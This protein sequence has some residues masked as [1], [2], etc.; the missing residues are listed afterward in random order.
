MAGPSAGD[1]S[2]SRGAPRGRYGVV[3]TTRAVVLPATPLLV[4]GAAGRARVLDAARR[5]ALDGLAGLPADRPVVV[6][7]AGTREEGVESAPA[8]ASLAAA[9]VADAWLDP[10]WTQPAGLDPEGTGREVVGPAGVGA[11]VALLALGATGRRAG[12]E[13]VEL[14]D[15]VDP[16]DA[17][18]LGVALRGRG[19]GLVVA[20]DPRRPALAAV[21]D[22]FVDAAWERERTTSRVDA[23]PDG[24][25]YEVVRYLTR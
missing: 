1:V 11:S 21:L 19:V 20:D 7:G 15:A 8:T 25:A 2:S 12:V 18:A 24:A 5:A 17:R 6:V 14:G 10:A 3:V 23:S 22:G 4:P 13:V 16:A 9:G